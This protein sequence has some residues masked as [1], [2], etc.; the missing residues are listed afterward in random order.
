MASRLEWSQ[1]NG[2][3]WSAGPEHRGRNIC[4]VPGYAV[5][6]VHGTWNNV[7]TDRA[8]VG[9]D[10]ELAVLEGALDGAQAG[11]GC[12]VVVTGSPGS[13]GTRLAREA[14]RVA[15]RRGME[16]IWPVGGGRYP[17]R[18]AASGR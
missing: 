3:V 1:P 15:V 16:V 17:Q 9:R 5:R 12:L 11:R 10:R 18:S 13:G 8:L 7:G 2:T 6:V 14:A 4:S